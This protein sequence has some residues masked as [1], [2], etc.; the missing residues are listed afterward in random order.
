MLSFY[1]KVISFWLMTIRNE[2]FETIF[3][4]MCLLKKNP[5][6]LTKS[7]IVIR[8]GNLEVGKKLCE[9]NYIF[10]G[11]EL[12]PSIDNPW[13]VEVP[14]KEVEIS[15]HGF[16]WLNDLRNLGTSKARNLAL[17]WINLWEEAYS[18][19]KKYS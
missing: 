11:V 6:K 14:S 3:V 16:S 19:G 8:D 1:G 10:G 17:E 5:R 7:I 12:D 18:K 15:M 13:L 4:N 2:F 9:G